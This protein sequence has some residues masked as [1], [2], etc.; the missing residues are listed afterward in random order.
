MAGRSSVGVYS[1]LSGS[2]AL[3]IT[4]LDYIHCGGGDAN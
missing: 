1:L 3:N 2:L 4:P